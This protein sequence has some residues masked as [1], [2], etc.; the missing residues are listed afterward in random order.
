MDK[1]RSPMPFKSRKRIS[2][3]ALLATSAT[4][5]GKENEAPTLSNPNFVQQVQQVLVSPQKPLNKPSTPSKQ[6]I[7]PSI[8][9]SPDAEGSGN[10]PSTT[11]VAIP[12]SAL[13]F[14]TKNSKEMIAKLEEKVDNLHKEIATLKTTNM[15]LQRQVAK[16]T[17]EKEDLTAQVLALEDNYKACQEQM[18]ALSERNFTLDKTNLQLQSELQ[19]EK[20]EKEKHLESKVQMIFHHQEEMT[21]MQKTVELKVKEQCVQVDEL[22]GSLLEKDNLVLDL[23]SQVAELTE[24]L[25][26]LEEREQPSKQLET[27]H[28]VRETLETKIQQESDAHQQA[29]QLSAEQL[30]LFKEK[31]FFSLA[32]ALKLTQ[33]LSGRECNVD[34]HELFEKAQE[35]NV[36]ADNWSGWLA[37]QLCKRSRS[38]KKKSA[39]PSPQK[40]NSSTRSTSKHKT[41]AP[42]TK[43]GQRRT[44]RK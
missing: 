6:T 30:E 4:T 26:A 23:Q 19:S 42:S 38:G 7:A 40:Q 5:H 11:H 36:D 27:I 43:N 14:S 41:P 16:G 12:T 15:S 32:V 33:A 35:Q 22:K 1:R 25:K 3:S 34:A 31:Y 29:M 21:I 44:G 9:L 13:Y 20:K 39:N 37:T 18:E 10:P 17:E 28:L 24:K 8:V 2:A